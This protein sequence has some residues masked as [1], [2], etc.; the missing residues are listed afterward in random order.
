MACEHPYEKIQLRSTGSVRGLSGTILVTCSGCGNNLPSNQGM[1]IFV[2]GLRDHVLGLHKQVEALGGK[3]KIPSLDPALP[4]A[5]GEV[6]AP[7]PHYLSWLQIEADRSSQRGYS[8]SNRIKCRN[9]GAG[10]PDYSKLL[11]VMRQEVEA[12]WREIVRL[13]GKR[14]W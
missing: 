4:R 13:G 8:A 11:L 7:C 2:L 14:E 10:W 1:V 6:K 3:V 12:M 5:R 9:C